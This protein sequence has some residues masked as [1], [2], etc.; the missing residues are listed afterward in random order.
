MIS[1]KGRNDGLNGDTRGSESL[2][3]LVQQKKG[4]YT[5]LD[6]THKSNEI[7]NVYLETTQ[8]ETRNVLQRTKEMNSQ[9]GKNNLSYSLDVITYLYYNES[10][11]DI[12]KLW[13]TRNL[14]NTNKD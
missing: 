8:Q 4:F 11:K 14:E 13:K 3:I 2:L 9:K 5:L 10:K 1:P 6:M 12:N 7:E